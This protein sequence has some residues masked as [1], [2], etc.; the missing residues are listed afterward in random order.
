MKER[1]ILVVIP[2]VALI[3]LIALV[4]STAGLPQGD[5]DVS[6]IPTWHQ[7]NADGFGEAGNA[8][9]PS[10]AV[11]DDC[12]YAGTWYTDEVGASSQIWRTVDGANWQQ[13]GADFG[14]GAAHLVAFDG[15]LYVGSWDGNIWRSP[16]GLTWT[17]VI[18]SGFQDNGDGIAR[19]TVFSDTLYV[20]TW[21]NTG[22]Q[23]WRT[24]DGVDWTRFGSDGLGDVNNSGAI[25]SEVF[26]GSLYLGLGNWHTGAQLWHTD[27]ITWTVVVTDGFGNAD[28]AAVSSLAAFDGYLYAGLWNENG[29]Q[30]WRSQDGSQ[31]DQVVNGGLGNPE[32][33]RE[34]ALEVFEGQ[35]YLVAGNG[36]TGLE[37][38]RTADGLNWE[39]VGFA[40][41]GDG[42]NTWSFWDNAVTVFHRGLYVGINNFATGGEIWRTLPYQ[43]CLPYVTKN[44]GGYAAGD[45][46][47][48]HNWSNDYMQEYKAIAD[49]FNLSHPGL[50]VQFVYV[51][52]LSNALSV[53]IPAG[54]GPD[55]VA[56]NNDWIGTQ[57]LAGYIVALDNHGIDLTFLNTNYEPAAVQAMLWNEQI[58]GVPEAQEGIALVYNRDLISDT[59]LPDPDDFDA[60]LTGAAQFQQSH[61]GQFL[62]CN[63]GLGNPDA[64]HVAPIYF[65]H[66][67]KDYGGYVD[68]DGQVYMTTTAAI[69]AAHWISDFRPYAPLETSHDICRNMLLNGDTAMWWT[70]PWAIAD[71][72]NAGLDYGIAPMGSPFVGV[73]LFMMTQNA[74]DRGNVE[75]A[76]YVMKYFGSAGV[77]KRLTLVNGTVPAN[78]AA[79]ND[80]DV[81]ALY[82]IAQFGASLNRGTPMATTPYSGAQWGPV[83]DATTAIWIG[84]Q[85][86]E[87]AMEAAQAAIEEAIEQMGLR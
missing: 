64:Y 50:H 1:R 27:G 36:D 61:P 45:I 16:D 76:I 53:A 87:E 69:S 3:A 20:G 12:L 10:L 31:W 80:P 60:L 38:W 32:T 18:T 4:T 66:G 34:N 74:V 56:W 26:A 25:A 82:N 42:N 70:G 68:D 39:Q 44:Y 7:V 33:S 81:Q 8:Q 24:A 35:L 78:T 5:L 57:A 54:E 55:I 49:E 51:E 41:F 9:I 2:G 6:S 22:T 65:G 13:V 72:E 86:P 75:A 84:L 79:L 29:V 73:K 59:M 52:D 11:F 30:V 28:N 62:L 14:N 43:V 19:F 63:Q 58:W 85:T 48:W 46:T 23:I 71:I 77:Q 47:I 40:G 37:V 15:Y 17:A 21:S 83:G 67:L